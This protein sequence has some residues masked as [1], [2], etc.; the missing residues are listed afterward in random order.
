[1]VHRIVFDGK[2]ATGVKF[3]LS[4]LVER[5]NAAREMILSVGGGCSP[6]PR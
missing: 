2:R 6:H 1:M 3:S 5:A 4:G